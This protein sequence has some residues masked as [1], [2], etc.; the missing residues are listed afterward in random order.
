MEILKLVFAWI[1]EN[2]FDIA[3]VAVGASALITYFLQKK[4]E[5]RAAATLI[6]GQVDCIEEQISELKHKPQLNND[7]MYY[8][9]SILQENMWERYK[10]LFVNK[11]SAPEY[12]LI[13]SFFD[14]TGTLA[15]VRAEIVDLII[16]AWHD[17]SA[18][19]HKIIAD[20]LKEKAQSGNPVE[21]KIETFKKDF[22]ECDTSF[23]PNISIASLMVS[24]NNYYPLS[25]TT[26]YQKLK[27]ISFSK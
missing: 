16:T 21:Q 14:N 27:K 19:S 12:Q 18:V 25:G 26:A 10:H 5:Y 15:R 3:L 17:K 20:L 8:V 13:Q 11:L 2:I 23:T 22:S 1:W 7:A 4:N 6:I 9:K 24:L